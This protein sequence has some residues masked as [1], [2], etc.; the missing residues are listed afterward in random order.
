MEAESKLGTKAEAHWTESQP[1][2]REHQ[3]FLWASEAQRW[4]P[5]CLV[6]GRKEAYLFF[7]K[8]RYSPRANSEETHK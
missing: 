2:R 7:G 4:S 1:T 5:V 3:L 6:A 8:P